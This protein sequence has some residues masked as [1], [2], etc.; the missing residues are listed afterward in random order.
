MEI[1]AR[2][3]AYADVIVVKETGMAHR[4][5]MVQTVIGQGDRWDAG[6]EKM[7]KV[8]VYGHGWHPGCEPTPDIDDP[9]PAV[10]QYSAGWAHHLGHPGCPDCWP[11]NPQE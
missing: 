1:P 8:P 3:R 6:L 4:P 10:V 5:A 2:I 9:V 11:D 7:V